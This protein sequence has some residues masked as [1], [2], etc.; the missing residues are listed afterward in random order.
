MDF[1]IDKKSNR[2]LSHVNKNALDNIGI[3]H[4]QD[5]FNFTVHVRG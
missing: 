3:F 1:Y 5:H 4:N 2:V